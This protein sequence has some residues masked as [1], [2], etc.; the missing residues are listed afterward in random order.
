MKSFTVGKARRCL[1]A[2][3]RIFQ[4]TYTTP[5]KRRPK[6]N[7][8]CGLGFFLPC[9][10]LATCRA[11]WFPWDHSLV[12]LCHKMNAA[13]LQL[14][15]ISYWSPHTH[16]PGWSYT[17]RRKTGLSD[18]KP[19]LP[20]KFGNRMCWLVQKTLISYTALK[21]CLLKIRLTLFFFFFF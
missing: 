13:S 4:A 1:S 15:H 18:K 3:D 11:C 21:F 12:F 9:L 7:Q 16:S 14:D 20:F 19:V 2:T 10:C 5:N 17:H 6:S 8:M